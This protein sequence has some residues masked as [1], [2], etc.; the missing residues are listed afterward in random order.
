VLVGETSVVFT[1][2]RLVAKVLRATQ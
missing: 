2:K 1:D